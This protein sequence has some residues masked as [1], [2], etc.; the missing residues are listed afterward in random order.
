MNIQ[1]IQVTRFPLVVITDTHCNVKRISQIKSLYPHSQFICLG[2]ITSL[3][4][5]SEPFNKHSINYFI[6]NKIP[7]IEGNHEKFILACFPKDPKT[8]SHE[9]AGTLGQVLFNIGKA[10]KYNLENGHIEYLRGLPKGFK[11][12]LPNGDHYIAFHHEPN[13]VWNFNDKGQI[14]VEKFKGIYNVNEKT[15]GVLHGH[16]HKSFVEEFEG[17]RAKRYS[18]GAV[19]YDDYAILT[20]D[21]IQFKK[22]K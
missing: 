8:L 9:E 6:E 16:V 17:V 5:E 13:N 7:C 1:E 10:P 15:V 18:I 14:N 22:L 12:N 20:E 21:G 19:K 4:A 2:D 11:I 3:F